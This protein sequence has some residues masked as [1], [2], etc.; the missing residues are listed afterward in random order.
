[1]KLRLSQIQTPVSS[2]KEENLKTVQNALTALAPENPDFVALG[3]MF[4]CPY[5]VE[6]FPK[7]AEA[8][9]G[10]T[11]QYLSGLARRFHVYLSA[12][13][14]AWGHSLV[15]SPWGEILKE[16]DEKAGYITTDIDLDLVN[17]VREQLPLLSARRTDV[18]ELREL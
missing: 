10:E 1:M 2:D 13:Y 3:E 9:G 6:N 18:Y 12:G 16:A 15:V 14:V 7:Y 8:E 5:A 17:Q 11:W 4:D